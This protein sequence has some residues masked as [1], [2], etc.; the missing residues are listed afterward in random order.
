MLARVRCVRR[1]R[2]TLNPSIPKIGGEGRLHDSAGPP[3]FS[4]RS[5][6]RAH[7]SDTQDSAHVAS[8]RTEWR[9]PKWGGAFEN[10]NQW[11]SCGAFRVEDQLGGASPHVLPLHRGFEKM[12]RSYGPVTSRRRRTGSASEPSCSSR[13]PRFR[14]TACGSGSSSPPHREPADREDIDVHSR[15]THQRA[16]GPPSRGARS[17]TPILAPR[18]IRTRTDLKKRSVVME[19]AC[20]PSSAFREVRT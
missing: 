2:V 20:R 18:G 6:G 10:A 19:L 14:G 12:V 17:G 16:E 1:R 15:A 7:I 3:I 4:H 9:C 5:G 8:R 13:A 11:H